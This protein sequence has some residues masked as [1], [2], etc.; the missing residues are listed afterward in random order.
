VIADT[1][2]PGQLLLGHTGAQAQLLDPKPEEPVNI[3]T[4][5]RPI[6]WASSSFTELS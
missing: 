4:R 3:R 1:E 5:D 6:A 2:L